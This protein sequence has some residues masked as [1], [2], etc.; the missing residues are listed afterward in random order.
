MHLAHEHPF[1][2]HTSIA[3]CHCA[4]V[5]S[6]PS[7]SS[8]PADQ[9]RFVEVVVL[10]AVCVQLAGEAKVRDLAGCHGGKPVLVNTAFDAIYVT[11][12]EARV[13]GFP[14]ENESIGKGKEPI[15]YRCSEGLRW[16]GVMVLDNGLEMEVSEKI[17]A[18]SRSET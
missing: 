6:I 2:A 10:L 15:G 16:L 18:F 11:V 3:Q 1:L 7:S 8:G 13:A 14:E 17:P 9:V 12:E 4:A 5:Y